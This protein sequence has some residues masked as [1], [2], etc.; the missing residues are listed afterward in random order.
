MGSGVERK[1][2]GGT[3]VAAR[4]VAEAVAEAAAESATQATAEAVV[5]GELGGL[6]PDSES[7][8]AGAREMLEELGEAAPAERDAVLALAPLVLRVLARGGHSERDALERALEGSARE[9]IPEDPEE[10]SNE[11]FAELEVENLVRLWDRYRW[12]EERS[13][14]GPE[15][16]ERLGGVSR[17]RLE[18]LRKRGRLFGLMLPFRGSYVYPHWQFD[19]ETGEGLEDLPRLLG[20]AEEAGVG[21]LALDGFM[22]SGSA[23]EDG[24]PSYRMFRSGPEGRVLVLGALRAALSEGS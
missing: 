14:S 8:A 12:I 17:Q 7:S 16:R 5:L 10:M 13:L 15:L 24:V 1:A 6:L 3:E 19:P 9:E 21:P 23:G 2:E 22:V 18:Q 20:T 4:S 11:L